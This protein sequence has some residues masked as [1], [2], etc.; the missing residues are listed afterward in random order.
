[1][2]SSGLMLRLGSTKE[3]EKQYN[4]GAA[5]REYPLPDLLRH[6]HRQRGTP[7]GTAHRRTGSGS[8]LVQL[9]KRNRKGVLS[10]ELPD[11]HAKIRRLWT[12]LAAKHGVNPATCRDIK[13]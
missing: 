4:E 11:A 6:P 9:L 2:F 8:G 7:G 10:R 5:E 12:I 13:K 1:M 3:I